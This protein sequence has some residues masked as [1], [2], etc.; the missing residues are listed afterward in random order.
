MPFVG[1]RRGESRFQEALATRVALAQY[2]EARWPVGRRKAVEREWRLSPDEARGVIEATASA[3][4]IDKVFRAGGW[5]VALPI[6]SEVIGESLDVFLQRERERSL[7]AAHH[8][9]TLRLQVRALNDQPPA[10]IVTTS[11]APPEPE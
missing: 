11:T 1:S 6:L 3:A 10:A 4:T 7:K 2:C 8:A 5:S 9:R